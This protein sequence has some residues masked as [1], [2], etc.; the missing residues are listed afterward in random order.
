MDRAGLDLRVAKNNRLPQLDLSFSYGLVG[1]ES[2]YADTVDQLF[3]NDSRSWSVFLNMSWTPLGRQARAQIA[4]SKLAR[5]SAQSR[6]ERT[7]LQIYRDVRRA[8][9]DLDTAA[10]Q[11]RAAAKFRDLASRALDVEQRKFLSGTSSNFLVTQRQNALRQ[12]QQ[13]ELQALIRHRQAITS[14]Q[15]TTGTLLDDRKIEVTVR[16]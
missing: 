6:L 2:Q 15:R 5:V 8:V 1:Q 9:R 13:S 7:Q 11:L 16:R 14:L 12:A 10:R 4:Q 3:S